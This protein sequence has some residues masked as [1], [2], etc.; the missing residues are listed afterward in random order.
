[1]RHFPRNKIQPKTGNKSIALSLLPHAGQA[2]GGFTIDN[3][4]GNL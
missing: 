3:F 2:E 1:M 4:F